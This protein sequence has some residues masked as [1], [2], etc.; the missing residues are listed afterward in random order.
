MLFTPA[1][2]KSRLHSM[3]FSVV[4]LVFPTFFFLIRYLPNFTS[5]IGIASAQ[6]SKALVVSKHLNTPTLTDFPT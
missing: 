2:P 3:F 1:S 5:Y 4:F 6:L